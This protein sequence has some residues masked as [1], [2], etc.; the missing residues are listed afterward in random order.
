[1]SVGDAY[2]PD[3]RTDLRRPPTEKK[4][5]LRLPPHHANTTSHYVMYIYW[6]VLQ[7]YKGVSQ[8]AKLLFLSK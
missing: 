2:I 1:M 7:I 5:I 4:N 8:K 6:Q 3:R